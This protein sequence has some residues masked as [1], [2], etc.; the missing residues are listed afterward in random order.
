MRGKV[1]EAGLRGRNHGKRRGISHNGTMQAFVHQGTWCCGGL[2]AHTKTRKAD[3]QRQVLRGLHHG[4]RRGRSHKGHYCVETTSP[5]IN[6]ISC[7]VQ[8]LRAW[9]MVVRAYE[10]HC[11]L[12]Q[13]EV[14]ALLG[15]GRRAYERAAVRE[16]GGGRVAGVARSKRA[17]VSAG[18]MRRRINTYAWAAWSMSGCKTNY[19]LG[20]ADESISARHASNC[21][22][23]HMVLWRAARTQKHARLSRTGVLGGPNHGKRRGS[24]NRSTFGQGK[25]RGQR[26]VR[27][28]IL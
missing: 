3:Q 18:L 8:W 6:N 11:F 26:D 17:K 4:K 20:G 25:D 10:N 23:R 13:R 1:R 28:C 21:L 14:T 24:T 2:H 5:C 19:L 7:P 15:G 27:V 9:C 22:S 12:V 16:E